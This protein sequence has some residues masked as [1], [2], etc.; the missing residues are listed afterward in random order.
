VFTPERNG[1]SRLAYHLLNEGFR[2]AVA[3]QPAEVGGRRWPRGT[4]IVRSARNDSTLHARIDLLAR[5]SG[6]E[7]TGVN[8]AFTEAGGQHGIGGESVVDL[9]V[10]RVA[11]VGDEGVSQTGYGAVWWTL[12]R[13]Y[14][15]QFTPVSTRWLSFGDLAQFNV[16]IIPDASAGTLDRI[17]GKSGAE[18][19]KSWA[20]QGGT[21][22]T[23]G[24]ASAWAA[25]ESVNLTSSRAVGPEGDKPDTTGVRPTTTTMDTVTATARRRE[26]TSDRT[27]D[28]EDLLAV[29]SPGAT[30]ASPM[31]LPGSHFDVVLDRTHWLS[32]GY[33]AP[34]VTVMLEG[35]T[36]FRLSKDGTNVGVFAPSGRLTRAGFTWP[37][38]T[39]RLLRN[40]AFLI[41]EPIGD[42]H[43]ILFAN[44]PMF[45]GWWRALDRLVLNGVVLGPAM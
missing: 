17:L 8:S 10:P 20:Q 15:L 9:R 6:V 3:T 32:Q 28:P 13:R 14:G 23:M 11:L 43:L 22:I 36:F 39:E 5:E 18:R 44:E 19:L 30:N 4:Y 2:V 45:R 1:A 33:E 12:E 41:E 21:L 35:S 7:V 37:D 26:R 42:G 34:R 38:N 16:I 40:T 24:G 25:R 29:T 31:Y 27:Q